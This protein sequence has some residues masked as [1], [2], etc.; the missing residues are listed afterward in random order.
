MKKRILIA[1]LLCIAMLAGCAGPGAGPDDTPA[2]ATPEAVGTPVPDESAAPAPGG[3]QPPATAAPRPN[4]DTQPAETA[5]PVDTPPPAEPVPTPEANEPTAADPVIGRL[6]EN[7]V[8]EALIVAYVGYTEGSYDE[9]MSYLGGNGIFEEFPFAEAIGED[10]FCAREGGELYV[11]MPVD[12]TATLR[13]NACDWA[14]KGGEIETIV[15]AEFYNSDSGLPVLLKGNISDIFS[16]LLVTVETDDGGMEYSPYMSLKDGNLG[17]EA[18]VYDA[19][20][21]VLLKTPEPMTGSELCGEWYARKEHGGAEMALKLILEENGTAVFSYGYPYEEAIESFRGSWSEAEGI[22]SLFLYGGGEGERYELNASYRAE[23]QGIALVC[24]HMGG[25]P[26]L[27]G[28]HGGWFTFRPFDAFKL[29]GIWRTSEPA[30]S[31]NGEREY[32]LELKINGEALYTVTEYAE[33]LEDYQGWWSYEDGVLI[34]TLNMCGGRDYKSGR[35][36]Y[37]SYAEV[38]N[39]MAELAL[40]LKYGDPLTD[41]M[42]DNGKE[43]FNRSYG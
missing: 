36:I 26:L 42:K 23:L 17:V 37:G 39:D 32:F 22:L 31:G 28:M 21:Y 41:F 24:E 18:G 8:G 12:P 25:D 2:A 7:A 29:N 1:L 34:L 33:V 13:V 20:P 16:N 9:V 10:R 30:L 27:S 38:E 14:D 4:G 6:R 11:V 40:E 43:F 5:P 3:A 35:G 19:T 15:G